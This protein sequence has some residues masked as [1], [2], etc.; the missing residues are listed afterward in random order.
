VQGFATTL[1]GGLIGAMI[2]QGFDGTLTP[3]ASGYFVVSVIGLLLVLI[4]ERGKL[5]HAVNQPV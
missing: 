1:G 3:L 5:F 4:G 2:G